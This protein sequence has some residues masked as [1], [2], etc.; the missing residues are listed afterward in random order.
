MP[1]AQWDSDLARHCSV[2]YLVNNLTSHVLFQEGLSH[3]PHDALVLEIGPHDLL[4]AILRRSLDKGVF[5]VGVMKREHKDNVSYMLNS[6]GKY[7]LYCQ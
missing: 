1:E 2:Q 6:L 3:V 5:H 7:V 4:Q